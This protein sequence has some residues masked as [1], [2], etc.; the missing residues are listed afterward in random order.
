MVQVGS[1]QRKTDGKRKSRAKVHTPYAKWLHVF[2][3]FH[4]NLPVN[5]KA[6][7]FAPLLLRYTLLYMIY[8]QNFEQKIGF[9]QIRTLL[10]AQC[11]ST[12]GQERVD[13]MEFSDKRDDIERQ[14]NETTEFVRIIEE[15]VGFPDQYFLDVR[16]SL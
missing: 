11:L 16:P 8:P 14:L 6:V 13:A 2:Y 1:L 9:D 12:L 10:K 15:E 7:N 3:I 5:S 4:T